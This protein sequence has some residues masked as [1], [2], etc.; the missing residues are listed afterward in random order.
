MDCIAGDHNLF[1]SYS[2]ASLVTES[3]HR[4]RGALHP[5]SLPCPSDFVVEIYVS[6]LLKHWLVKRRETRATEADK[7]LIKIWHLFALIF[8]CV[9]SKE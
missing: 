3:K 7:E 2:P 9:W 5:D 6:G 1:V 4:V 8:C